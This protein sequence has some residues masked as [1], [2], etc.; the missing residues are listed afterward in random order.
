MEQIKKG[1]EVE[2]KGDKYQY[3]KNEDGLPTLEYIDEKYNTPV[4]LIFSGEKTE[5][6]CLSGFIRVLAKSR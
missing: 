2:L 1:V 4:R 5:E 3:Y 6:E